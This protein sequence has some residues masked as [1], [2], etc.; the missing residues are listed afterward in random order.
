MING[1][2]INL[3]Q[4]ELERVSGGGDGSAGQFHVGDLVAAECGSKVYYFGLILE[5]NRKSDG[6]IS[7]VIEPARAVL[8]SITTIK[9]KDYSERLAIINSYN[10]NERIIKK[11]VDLPEVGSHDLHYLD[12]WIN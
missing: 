2:E 5:I 11:I 7:Y 3:S 6:S 10:P 8:V 4:E 9:I 12:K 1:K